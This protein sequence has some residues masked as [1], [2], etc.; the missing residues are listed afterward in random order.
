MKLTTEV[1][2]AEKVRQTLLRIGQQPRLA[3]AQTAEDLENYV[4]DEAAKHN[5][6]GALVRSV[7]KLRLPD[8][9][10]EIGHDRQVAPEALFV[11]WGTKPHKIKPKRK[12][13]LRWP[14]FDHYVFAKEVNHPGYKGD[15]WLKRAAALAPIVF[16]RHVQAL[17][18]NTPR[19]SNG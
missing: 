4:E 5:K 2:G 19:G 9:N 7:Y 16:D 10:W 13:W 12:K 17:L 11:H 18:A 3:L 6:T 14:A 8:G 15:P 1:S